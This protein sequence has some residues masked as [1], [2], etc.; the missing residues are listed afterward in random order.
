MPISSFNKPR[1]PTLSSSIIRH[2]SVYSKEPADRLLGSPPV[3][4]LFRVV[5]QNDVRSDAC[6]VRSFSNTSF[7]LL[8]KDGKIFFSEYTGR[9]VV[10]ELL[11]SEYI[12]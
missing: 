9:T 10:Y 7:A 6:G 12:P 8:N 3:R 11:P 1:L 5:S 4:K 2:T